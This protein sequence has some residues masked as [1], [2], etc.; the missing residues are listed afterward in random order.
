MIM[1]KSSITDVL[2]L[3][4]ATNKDG[5][6]QYLAYWI[7]LFMILTKARVLSYNFLQAH[8]IEGIE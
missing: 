1:V 5:Q 6:F 2:D 8:D 7:R 4:L 3:H